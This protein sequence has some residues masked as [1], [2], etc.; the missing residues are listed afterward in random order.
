[1]VL[2]VVALVNQFAISGPRRHLCCQSLGPL[3]L[4]PLQHE[5]LPATETG[6]ILGHFHYHA[7]HWGMY[8]KALRRALAAV[9]LFTLGAG[10][11]PALSADSATTSFGRSLFAVLDDSDPVCARPM[12]TSRRAL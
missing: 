4:P 11:P 10:A 6:I 7:G 1:M 3:L 2:A 12:A 5:S 8:G 9:V